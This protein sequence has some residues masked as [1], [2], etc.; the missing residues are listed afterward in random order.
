MPG[1]ALILGG[2]D[3]T[4]TQWT[5]S[6]NQIVLLP[7]D[8]QT[9]RVFWRSSK[10]APSVFDTILGPGFFVMQRRSL[11]G[12][13]ERAEGVILPWFAMDAGLFFW[14]LCFL[15]FLVSVAATALRRN[16]QPSFLASVIAALTTLLL[17]LS[18]PPVWLDLLGALLVWIAV[19]W[20]FT[21]RRT[22]HKWKRLPAVA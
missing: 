15:G 18:M 12:I 5:S 13:Q 2:K 11:I 14:L 21:T 8:P 17:V 7:I 22:W 10:T 19:V 20:S 16:W 9:T 4:E 6:I 1:Q 3:E